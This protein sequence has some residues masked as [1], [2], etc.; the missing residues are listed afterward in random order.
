MSIKPVQNQ[1]NGGEISPLMEGR[2]DLPAYQ[3]S[4]SILQNFIPISEGCY[5]R[6]GGTHF[7]SSAKQVGAVLFKVKTEPSNAV[8]IIDGVEQNQCWSAVGDTVSYIVSA[9]GYVSQ[10]GTYKVDGAKEIEVKLVSSVIRCAFE[11][12]AT[13]DDAV[14]MI[15][16]LERNK[17]SVGQNSKI[18]WS[19]SKQG[20]FTQSG[21][22]NAISENTKVN[23]NL[24]MR[25]SIKTNIS[26]AEILINGEKRSYIDVDPLTEVSWSVSAEGYQTRS[27]TQSVTESV[28]LLVNLS[29]QTPGQVMFESSTPGTYNQTLEAGYY[30][31]LM[32]GAGGSGWYYKQSFASTAYFAQGGAGAVFEGRLYLNDGVYKIVV[33]GTSGTTACEFSDIVETGSGTGA[34]NQ[35]TPGAG[36]LLTVK[37]TNEIVEFLRQSNGTNGVAGR[38]ANYGRAYAALPDEYK[39]SYGYGAAGNSSGYTGFA[40][41]DNGVGAAFVKLVYE[42]I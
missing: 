13:P 27:G 23:V 28:E 24:K 4:A 20:Y 5:K 3:Y 32:C 16:G 12:E 35:T 40:T 9:D 2:F 11:I 25:F 39:N 17:I 37:S 34:S 41:Q 30:K 7:V 1:F 10:G 8:V 36:G 29:S 33:G 26:S 15:N 14:V 18:E 31:L 38:G 6:R 22:I 21:I 42:G 19:V